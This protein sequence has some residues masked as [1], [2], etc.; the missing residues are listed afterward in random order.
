MERDLQRSEGEDLMSAVRGEIA[1]ESGYIQPS[2]A[3]DNC[4]GQF[5]G[6]VRG[7][8]RGNLS[9]TIIVHTVVDTF[10]APVNC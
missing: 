2:L 9:M 6:Q 10:V 7:H 4:H 8:F 3:R 1:S 5:R